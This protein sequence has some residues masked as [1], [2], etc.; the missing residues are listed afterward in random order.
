[1][2]EQTSASGRSAGPLS[3]LRVVEF[4]GLGP[5]PHAAMLLADLGADVVRID[6][7]G[8]AKKA[9]V[10]ARGRRIVE[11]DLKDAEALKSVLVLLD[12]ADVLIEGFRPG[13]MERL[14][15]GPDVLLERNP[16]LVYGRMTGWG[17][18]GP[19]APRAGH[20]MAYIA[21]TGLA[22][23][24]GTS[25]DDAPVPPL[26]LVGDFGGGSMFLV[27]GIL[28]ALFER[29]TTDRGQVVDAAIVDGTA[30][31]GTMMWALKDA[32]MYRDSRGV[33]FVDGSQPSYRYYKTSDG[34]Y[35]AVAPLEPQFF[36]ELRAHLDL[37]DWTQK[38]RFDPKRAGEVRDLIADRIAQHPLSHWTEVFDDTDACVAPVWS[39]EQALEDPHLKARGTY[40]EVDGVSQPRPAPRFSGHGRLDP[41]PVSREVHDPASIAEDWAEE[42]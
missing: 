15:L 22:S 6:R 31:L 38:A 5:G 18:D 30:A 33:N 12:K 1:M 32:G 19:L 27:M 24:V 36:E 42:D 13:V 29:S 28:A 14:G 39:M 26:N 10:S 34:E 40:T 8:G 16:R 21:R 25:P 37:P 7:P 9:D 23:L 20:D 17:Q 41:K 3:G 4:T 11:A 35:L 2:T